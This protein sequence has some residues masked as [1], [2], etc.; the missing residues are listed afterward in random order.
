MPLDRRITVTL[1]AP[2]DRDSTGRYVPGDPTDYNL[3]ATRESAGSDDAEDG[4]LLVSQVVARWTVRYFA[5]LAEADSRDVTVTAGN[6]IWNCDSIEESDARRRFITLE[7][8]R[9]S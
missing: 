5:A 4:G 7:C 9:R 2:G 3:W 8:G 6:A 1:T